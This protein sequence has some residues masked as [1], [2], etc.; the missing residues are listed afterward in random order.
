MVFPAAFLVVVAEAQR[1]VVDEEVAVGG[2]G[3]VLVLALPSTTNNRRSV[4]NSRRR[5]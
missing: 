3:I 5:M 4:W 1:A 2:F